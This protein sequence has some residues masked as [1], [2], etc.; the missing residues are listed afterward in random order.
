[1]SYGENECNL[2]N[3]IIIDVQDL[4]VTLQMVG[5]NDKRILNGLSF[6]VERGKTIALVGSSGSGKSITASAI[7]RILPDNFRISGS[8]MFCG[9]P[10][11]HMT[12]SELCSIRG[13]Q[14][15]LIPQEPMTALNP[16]HTVKAQISEAILTHSYDK[17]INKS[18]MSDMCISYL[19][20]V[21]IR[22]PDKKLGC[23][24]HQLSGGE[25]Q[26]VLICMA[27]VHNPLLLVADEPTTA[28]D[29]RTRV[30][31]LELLESLQ[32]EM[33]ISMV[34]I[35][36][37]LGMVHRIAHNVCVIS[38]G[39]IVESAPPDELLRDGRH[40]VT[41]RLISES[42]HGMRKNTESKS[43]SDVIMRLQGVSVKVCQRGRIFS[44]SPPPIELLKDINIYVNTGETLGIVGES[45]SGKTTLGMAILRLLNI[46]EGNHIFMGSRIDGKS[47]TQ[48]RD[49][50]KNVQIVFQDPFGSLNPRMTV[51]QIVL[52]GVKVHKKITGR[53]GKEMAAE[54]IRMVQMDPTDVLDRYPHEFSGGQR[55]RIAIARALILKP[56]LIVLDEATSALDT[57]TQAKIIDLL[58]RLQDTIGL[59]YVFISH[60]LSVVYSMAHRI[61][62]IK[63]GSIVEQGATDTIFNHPENPYV[64]TLVECAN[65]MRSIRSIHSARV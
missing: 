18:D 28:L 2:K 16:L 35:S 14:I 7:L 34:F 44:R 20:K 24:P 23:Y 33:Q 56:S 11:K 50:R 41:Q 52:E 37:D 48:L 15:S 32:E 38:N 25:R 39:R 42:Q 54:V 43:T 13:K 29:A 63:D 10:M 47:Q 26:R 27:I 36:H 58:I 1:M 12:E 3:N 40:V 6:S 8:V 59:S 9:R 19:S 4:V 31:V 64:K 53:V 22:N 62:V 17:R 30:Q 21:G 61:A 65:S 45:G 5:C 57:E 51:E 55:Q 49:M 46:S 60:D